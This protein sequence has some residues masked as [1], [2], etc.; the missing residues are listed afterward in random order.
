MA[1][2]LDVLIFVYYYFASC[3]S[4]VPDYPKIGW[5]VKDVT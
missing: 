5:R 4:N 3:N 1:C 2:N